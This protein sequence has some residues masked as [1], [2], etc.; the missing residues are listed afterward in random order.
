MR[1][2]LNFEF[3]LPEEAEELLFYT[4]ADKYRYAVEEIRQYLRS[5]RK[6]AEKDPSFEE[7][8]EKICD[9]LKEVWT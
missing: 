6:Y 5:I 1:V 9:I 4:N 7:I 2:N 8:D 3:D